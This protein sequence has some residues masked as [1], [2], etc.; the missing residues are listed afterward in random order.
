M[1]PNTLFIPLTLRATTHT[2]HYVKAR[3]C[4][5]RKRRAVLH[6]FTKIRIVLPNR[7]NLLASL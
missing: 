6:Q 3:L 4:L 7:A 2:L 5:V 1:L